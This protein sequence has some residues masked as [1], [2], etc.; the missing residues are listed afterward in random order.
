MAAAGTLVSAVFYLFLPE[1]GELMLRE[2]ASEDTEEV[3]LITDDFGGSPE[4]ADT[5][6]LSREG[7]TELQM[8]QIEEIVRK[9]IV[10]ELENAV[11]DS[12]AE[13][14]TELRD[15]GTLT[16]ALYTYAREQSGKLNINTAG[17]QELKSLSGIGDAK[18]SAIIRYREENGGFR[19]I[20]DLLN[21]S[22][23]SEK[24]LDA[25]KDDITV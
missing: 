2:G 10:S 21:V 23:I 8:T 24:I 12:V 13:A 3:L 11:R 25:I 7:F 6:A 17:A 19:S 9:C 15:D 20:E 18:A 4:N 1:T 22:G 5:D 14:I 16:E